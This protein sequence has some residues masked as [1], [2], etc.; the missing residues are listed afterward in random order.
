[1][2]KADPM[3]AGYYILASA[4]FCFTAL[5]VLSVF[6]YG[7]FPLSARGDL[8]SMIFRSLPFLKNSIFIALIVTPASVLIGLAATLAV[9]RFS[10]PL[11]RFFK[12]VLLLSLIHPPFVGSIA[13]IMLFGKRGLITHD[14]LRL[15]V[16]PYGWQGIALLQFLG[17]G[18]MAYLI[19]SSSV[20]KTNSHIEAAARNLG[21]PEGKIFRDITLRTMYPE[22]SSAAILVFLASMADF[23]TPLIIGGPFQT[24]ASD[25]YIQITGLYDMRSASVSGILL[26]IPCIALF[27]YQR[28][29][30]RRKAYY[31][32][33]LSD[34][35]IRYRHYSRPV[36][37]AALTITLLYTLFIFFKY[38]FIFVG[39]FTE[40]WGYDYTLTLRHL[41]KVLQKDLSP[42]VNSVQLAFFTALMASTAGVFLSYAVKRKKWAFLTLS[43]VLATLPAAVPGILLGIGYLVTFKYPVLGIGRFVLKE[44]PP[45]I[46]LGTGIIIYIICIF[47][48][49]NVGLRTGYALLEHINP[50]I[51]EA[52]RNLGQSENRIF[53]GVI[54]PL[55]SPAFRTS[56]FKI[57]STTMTTLGAIIFL[58]LPSNKVA[59]QSIFQIIT[60]S[61]RGVAASMALLLSLTTALMLGFF[62]LLNYLV[63]KKR[64]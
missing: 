3:K 49:M 46:L 38:G 35:S 32:M 15:D 54:M 50:N 8:G 59:V 34:G 56:F 36:R 33:A 64:L 29:L 42:F 13:F 17:M 62:R 53:A 60:S 28:R 26:L 20:G 31:A 52:A 55:L 40:H 39:A 14:L 51:E 48:Y 16:S 2:V 23:G 25:L 11:N 45:F 47:R 18:S 63:T 9:H 44:F 41:V 27:T 24:L 4:L 7:L 6:L 1:M 43:D 58:L 12:P 10:S 21:I 57:F 5:P 61:E 37:A 19:I 22:L 30:N